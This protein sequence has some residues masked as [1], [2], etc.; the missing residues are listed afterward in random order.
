ML[1]QYTEKDMRLR[2]L[3]QM[4][5]FFF[6]AEGGIRDHCVTGVQ[7]CALPISLTI[8]WA[9]EHVPAIVE[10]WFLGVETGPALAAVLF[11]DVN[12]S[13]KLPVSFP[14]AVGQIPLYYNHKNTGRPTGPD[15]YTSKYTDLPVTPLFPFGHGL[16]YTKIGRASCRE[17]V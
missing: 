14:R 7:T 12:P 13:G 3:F 5:N 6:Q 10:S 4:F 8:P 2:V 11:G 17:R 15:K 16:S 9:A 1:G